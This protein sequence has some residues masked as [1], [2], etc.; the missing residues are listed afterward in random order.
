[1]SLSNN[2][3]T[4]VILTAVILVLLVAVVF[5]MSRGTAKATDMAGHYKVE[6]VD[7]EGGSGITAEEL[8]NMENLQMTMSLDLYEDNTGTLDLFG[9]IVELTYDPK[10]L[11]VTIE[12]QEVPF[13]YE[14]GKITIEQDGT[15]MV[16]ARN[17]Q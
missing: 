17:K 8:E 11:T 14:E 1:M 2:K 16:F 7:S 15:K 5:I 12:E 4:I 3:K 13:T 10:K 9:Q 6:S